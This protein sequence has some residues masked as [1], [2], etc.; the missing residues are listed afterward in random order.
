[1]SQALGAAVLQALLDEAE[2]ALLAVDGEGRVL[3]ANAAVPALLGLDGAEVEGR[4][5][6]DLVPPA[7]RDAL[8]GLLAL[9]R[10]SDEAAVPA[11]RAE[12]RLRRL[13]DGLA[14]VRLRLLPERKPWAGDYSALRDFLLRLPY[15]V[16]A[17]GPTGTVEFANPQARV[18]FKPHELTVGAT[19]PDPWPSLS[20]HSLLERVRETRT[21]SPP[22]LVE[23]EQ[24]LMRVVA[25]PPMH[26]KGPL[27]VLENVTRQHRRERVYG[28]FVRNAAHQLR[29]PIAAISSAVEVLQ[30]GAKE[31]PA[32]RDRFLDHIERETDRLSRLT[33]ALLVLARADAGV[34]PP[35][36]EFVRLKPLLAEVAAVLEPLGGTSIEVTCDSAI[37]VFVERDLA[38]QAFQAIFE[39]AVRHSRDGTVSVRA[40][41]SGKGRVTVEVEDPGEGILPEHLERIAEPFYRAAIGS[42]GFGLGLAIASRALSVVDGS[43]RLTS[44]PG[45]G[46]LATIELPSAEVTST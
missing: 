13:D 39:N 19:L 21:A 11:G 40:W 25:L 4:R 27:L 36:L 2:E 7:A 44:A 1:V 46:T 41:N 32:D 16:V 5:L 45:R 26:Q 33:R 8:R 6:E 22:Q 31:V 34:Q 37:A 23:S 14:I 9:G 3:L 35:R 20:L 24:R 42:E 28:E 17:L 15:G 38:E 29:T 10:G 18:L 30:G 12:L 43:L